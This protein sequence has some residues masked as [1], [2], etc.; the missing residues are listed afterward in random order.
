[1]ERQF[2]RHAQAPH[3]HAG[4]IEWKGTDRMM[5]VATA[6]GQFSDCSVLR[7]SRS[8]QVALK[9]LLVLPRFS[10]W[11][12]LSRKQMKSFAR[13]QCRITLIWRAVLSA[14]DAAA[15]ASLGE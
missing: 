7:L 1:M 13:W 12:R 4:N 2:H 5:A 8:I 15:K 10:W 3:A 14:L 9:C 11:L 6:N